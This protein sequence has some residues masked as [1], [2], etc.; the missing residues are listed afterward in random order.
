MKRLLEMVGSAGGA[1][2]GAGGYVG[3]NACEGF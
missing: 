2:E 1:R 3:V